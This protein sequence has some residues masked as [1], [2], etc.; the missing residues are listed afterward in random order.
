MSETIK[1]RADAVMAR[2][3]NRQPLV[4]VKGEGC[5]LWDSEG[6]KYTDFLAGIAVCSLGH[7]HPAV[8]DAI[9][10]Q[11]GQL[12]HV[13]N[14]Y[15]TIP[16]IDLASWLVERSFADRV[17]FCNSGAEANEAAIKLARKYFSEKGEK[18]RYKILTMKQSFH[19]RTL[20][21]LAATGQRKIQEGFD[22]LMPGFDYVP[23]DDP[24]SLE[25][26]MSPDICAVM[27]EP[28]QGEGGVICHSAGYLEK[29]RRICDDHGALLIYDEI[30]TGVGRTGKLFAYQHSGVSPDIMTLAKAMGNGFPIG[31]MLAREEVAAAFTYGSHATTFGGTPV[32]CAA[33]LAVLNYIERENILE[34]CRA[35]GEYF[36]GRLMELKNKHAAIKEVRGMGLLLGMELAREG[37]PVVRVCMER[38]YIIN[39][40]QT[41][42]LRFAPPLIVTKIEI[43]GLIDCL[44]QVLAEVG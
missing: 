17:F 43:D 35:T 40:I 13:S 21:T 42:V 28:I 29:V 23:Y 38:G 34:K 36:K 24:E 7:A 4:F 3:Y 44:D 8:T 18:S 15:Y 22:P 31:A 19:G 26:S 39:C 9:C 41:N 32:I 33:A 11:A 16:Q 20:G 14:L 10:R 25:K 37:A 12:V 27:V 2:T 30:Q 5:T 1:A 6:R